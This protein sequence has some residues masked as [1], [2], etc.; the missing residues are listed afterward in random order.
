MA[1]RLL[2]V[3]F[4]TKRHPPQR[5]EASEVGAVAARPLFACAGRCDEEV[6]A[7]RDVHLLK[8]GQGRPERL[9]PIAPERQRDVVVKDFGL[10][11][12]PVEPKDVVGGRPFGARSGRVLE[13]EQRTLIMTAPQRPAG[14]VLER[15]GIGV[16][17][18]SSRVNVPGE[19]H[20]VLGDHHPAPVGN[21]PLLGLE[22]STQENLPL[23]L[24]PVS[25]PGD[26]RLPMVRIHRP[27]HSRRLRRFRREAT[28]S[29]IAVEVQLGRDRGRRAPQSMDSS[30]STTVP[31]PDEF[32]F[33]APSGALAAEY[34]AAHDE[35]EAESGREAHM[36]S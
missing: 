25:P 19:E 21:D 1:S 23:G 16:P 14:N 6:L 26:V 2:D 3:A 17:A 27:E 22:P 32:E 12:A 11:V 30:M 20:A 9:V 15:D 5:S 33:P 35:E 34:N 8:P 24:T 10:G 28:A 29:A 4:V 31:Q 36:R 7:P 18:G 13:P